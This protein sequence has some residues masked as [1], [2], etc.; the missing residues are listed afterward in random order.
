MPSANPANPAI[1][2]GLHLTAERRVIRPV[3]QVN[4]PG[5]QFLA[6]L[7]HE[8]ESHASGKHHWQNPRMPE[9]NPSEPM[10]R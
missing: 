6:E 9:N 7:R 10:I 2:E 3:H 1:S 4:L 8:V 5:P